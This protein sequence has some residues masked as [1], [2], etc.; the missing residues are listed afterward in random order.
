MAV[1]DDLLLGQGQRD[2]AAGGLAGQ[3]QRP[4]L[5]EPGQRLGALPRID[6]ALRLLVGQ[7]L[8][9]AHERPPHVGIH[10]FAV[11]AEPDGPQQRRAHP[12]R[13]Q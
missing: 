11:G 8:A 10:A 1:D 5:R 13:Q 9:A 4:D 2:T 12:V 6:P 3:P 7:L